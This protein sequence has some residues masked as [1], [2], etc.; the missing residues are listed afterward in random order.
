MAIMKNK[1]I[2][3]LRKTLGLTQKELA[4]RVKV[5]AIT[6][7]RWERGEQRPSSQAARQLARLS[8]R[9]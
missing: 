1:D 6:V 9:R 7:S 5:D 2:K 4:A 3:N 8:K